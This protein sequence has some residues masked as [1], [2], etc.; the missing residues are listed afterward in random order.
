MTKLVKKI[1][2]ALLI[3]ISVHFILDFIRI[4]FLGIQ[5]HKFILAATNGQQPLFKEFLSQFLLDTRFITLIAFPLNIAILVLIIILLTK[6]IKTL[7]KILIGVG[8]W[9]T[10][11]AFVGLILLLI[12]INK[13]TKNCAQNSQNCQDNKMSS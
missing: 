3:I 7:H 9:I 1:A 13:E 11:S 5:P 4:I 8:I 6:N 10:I 2:I 12:D